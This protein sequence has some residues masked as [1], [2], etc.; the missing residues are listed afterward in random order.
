MN[1]RVIAPVIVLAP[2]M[3]ISTLFLPAVLTGR[4]V[5]DLYGIAVW[6]AYVLG[7]AGI[8]GLVRA[9]LNLRYGAPDK[10]KIT[11]CLIAAGILSAITCLV[12]YA[13][14]PRN[15][16]VSIFAVSNL[17]Y[18]IVVGAVTI[19]RLKACFAS[20]AHYESSSQKL[21]EG[22]GFDLRVMASIIPMAPFVYLGSVT[23]YSIVVRHGL[24]SVSPYLSVVIVAYLAGLLGLVGLF[25]ASMSSSYSR[26]KQG[27]VTIILLACGVVAA[28]TTI[29]LY[30]SEA[31]DRV[32]VMFVIAHLLCPLVVGV[33]SIWRLCSGRSDDD[34]NRI[35]GKPA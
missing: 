12:L 28:V 19:G 9:S 24:E 22:G 15:N 11:M 35:A 10:A 2:P 1:I 7:V 25:L 20:P 3:L 26:P 4:T 18:P 29:V 23:V 34:R 27:K 31:K 32:A 5:W 30:S 14:A 13:V 8:V 21:H 6:I 17:C 33:D 16:L